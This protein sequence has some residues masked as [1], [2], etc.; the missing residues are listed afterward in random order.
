[1]RYQKWICLLGIVGSGIVGSGTAQAAHDP[2]ETVMFYCG[3]SGVARS[4][5]LQTAFDDFARTSFEPRYSVVSMESNVE[6]EKPVMLCVGL[7]KSRYW[8][9]ELAIQRVGVS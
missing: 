8:Q 3:G 6:F 4:S 2:D 5:Q 1:M 7:R 9:G